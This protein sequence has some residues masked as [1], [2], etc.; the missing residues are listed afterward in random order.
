MFCMH[1]RYRD[2]G[3]PQPYLLYTDRDCC[4]GSGPSKF[5][6]LFGGWDQLEVRQMGV[7]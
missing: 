2:A 1:G 5:L 3:F 6:Q 7:C 4:S